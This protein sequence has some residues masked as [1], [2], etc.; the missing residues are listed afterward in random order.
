MASGQIWGGWTSNTQALLEW[1]S[2]KGTGGSTVNVT[3][4]IHTN[5]NTSLWATLDGTAKITIDGTETTK[6]YPYVECGQNSYGIVMTASK[7]VSYYGAKTINISGSFPGVQLSGYING[8]SASGTATLD[9]TAGVSTPSV[10]PNPVTMGNAVTITAQT[11]GSIN[12]SHQINWSYTPTG[13]GWTKATEGQ[14]HSFT[15]T[16]SVDL[17]AP[18]IPNATQMTIDMGLD[19]YVRGNEHSYDK[20]TRIG[21]K[22]FS[23]TLEVPDSVKPSATMGT[24][25]ETGTV[26]SGWGWTQK[27]SKPKFSFTASN[28]NCKGATIQRNTIKVSGGGYN[29]TT[30]G[31]TVTCGA[32]PSSGTVTATGTTMDSRGR[33]ATCSTSIDVRPYVYPTISAAGAIRVDDNGNASEI[34]T[35]IKVSMTYN[36]SPAKKSSESSGKNTAS[37]TIR[38]RKKGTTA[39]TNLATSTSLATTL[40]NT[41]ATGTADLDTAYEVQFVVT[42]KVTTISTTRTVNPQTT[43]IHLGKDGKTMSIGSKEEY[44]GHFQCHLPADFGGKVYLNDHLAMEDWTVNG[45]G[46]FNHLIIACE[47]KHKQ[48]GNSR[49]IFPVRWKITSAVTIGAGLT[50][51]WYRGMVFMQNLREN[52]NYYNDMGEAL[53]CCSNGLYYVTKMGATSVNGSVSPGNIK[54][55][56]SAS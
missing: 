43:L 7:W 49:W 3:L 9:N 34:G 46:D 47:N 42:D 26:P 30:S 5:S 13:D 18:K 6:A 21:W 39:W 22:Q 23:L 4:K 12:Y 19:T 53:L 24:V 54:L 44:A 14:A 11:V 41:T 40:T 31:T 52:A 29:Q 55:I 33:S 51:G 45:E 25:T 36:V 35:R 15:W 32:V 28:A 16:P 17:F 50:V 27:L 2:T 48:T 8:A 38:Y 20:S 37:V 10:S 1:S 56:T